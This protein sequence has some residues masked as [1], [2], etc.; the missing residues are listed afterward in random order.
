MF[1][2]TLKSETSKLRLFI[3]MH[4]DLAR[5]N[6]EGADNFKALDVAKYRVRQQL[7]QVIYMGGKSDLYIV[8]EMICSQSEFDQDLSLYPNAKPYQSVT[9]DQLKYVAILYWHL[10]QDCLPHLYL[11]GRKIYAM[12]VLEQG[13]FDAQK[14]SIEERYEIFDESELDTKYVE[15]LKLDRTRIVVAFLDD[16]EEKIASELEDELERE[17][18]RE[19][20][21]E[22]FDQQLETIEMPW[23]FISDFQLNN[24]VNQLAL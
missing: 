24:L 6:I 17:P 1:K 9:L 4:N 23:T 15:K 20:V 3:K 8:D 14:K 12:S 21:A 22:S 10:Y 2:Y 18:T 19:E 7:N 5:A 16:I 11:D 13:V